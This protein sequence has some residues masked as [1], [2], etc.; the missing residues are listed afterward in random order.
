MTRRA[1]ISVSDKTGIEA[2]ARALVERG[3]ELLSTGGTLAALRAA[4]IPAT[5]VSDVTGFPEILDGRVK[6]L[7]PAIHGGILARREEGHLAQ[8]AEHGL[9]LIDLVCVNLYPFRETV[10]RGATFEEAIENIDIG[11][12]AMIRA[13]A[14]NHAGVLVLVDPADYGLAFQDEVSQT[15]RRRLAAKA[16][17]HTSDYD[18][19]IS[20]Y[21]AGA[22]EAGETL[23][24]HLTLDLSRIAAVRY[25]ENPHQPGAIY[26]LGTERGPVLDARLLSGKPMSFNNYADADA[27]W[28]LAQ[29][30]AAQEDQPPGTRAVCVAVKHAN[31]CG[32]AVADSVQAAWEQARDA[33][34]LSVFGGVVAVSRPVDLAAA[35]SM[36]GTFL[37]VLIAPD[38]TPEAVAWFAAKKP[39]LR[40]L[41]A[42]TAAH[43]GTLDVRP[44]AGGF[45]VQRRD[46]RPWDD[47]CPEV[48]TVRPPTEQEWGDLRFAWAVVKHARSN[49][50]VLAKNGVTVGLGA[51]A[52]SRIWAAERAVQNAGE[53]ARGA[54]LASEAFFPF[55][56]VVRLAAEAGVTAVLQPGGAKRDP[57]VIAAANELGLSMVFTG[58]RHFRH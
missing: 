7:H 44:L 38:V 16:F 11:G 47:L 48:V 57:E 51:G 55:D 33:D 41:V 29:E 15:D 31:P 20:T 52:V 8:L 25:G 50:V 21:L 2:F 43:P 58:S 35:Q 10:A 28:A 19:A 23:P 56:D 6:T 34:T 17:R 49:A 42:D 26:R 13:A 32:V 30:L 1:L 3:W 27:A 5:A 46:T 36:R 37:E 14:K 45:A 39:D 24:E 4:G 18:A 9:D 40:V 22:D 53:R 12:P 54:V